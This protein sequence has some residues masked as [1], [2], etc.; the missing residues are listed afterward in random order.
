MIQ[1]LL[2]DAG[3][4]K[5]GDGKLVNAA[6]DK[7]TILL[8]GPK[9]YPLLEQLLTYAQQEF[10]NLGIDVTLEIPEWSVHLDK[11]HKL[12]YDLLIQWWITPPDPDLYD[13]YFSKSSNNWW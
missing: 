7:F 9:G 10:T 8:N 3:W 11:Y 13:H 4:T 6:G 2:A 1:S 12:E 5:G